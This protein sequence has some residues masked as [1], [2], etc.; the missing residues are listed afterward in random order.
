[1]QA[2]SN[3]LAENVKKKHPTNVK[4]RKSIAEMTLCIEEIRKKICLKQSI[5]ERSELN[6]RIQTIKRNPGNIVLKRLTQNDI[7]R[8]LH[9]KK[10]CQNRQTITM[11]LRNRKKM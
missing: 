2:F 8:W 7:N 4:L 6:K 11:S 9:K 1:M 5:K 10:R 3:D